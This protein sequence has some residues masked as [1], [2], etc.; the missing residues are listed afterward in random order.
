MDLQI[1]AATVVQGAGAVLLASIGWYVRRAV[2]RSD[3]QA[4]ADR[5]ARVEHDRERGIQLS[6]IERALG[7]VHDGQTA[8]RHDVEAVR[9][10]MRTTA[11][12]VGR[13]LDEHDRLAAAVATSAASQGERI[14]STER[15]VAVLEDRERRRSGA[16][17]SRSG[18]KQ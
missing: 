1:D 7:E 3:R 6:G 10:E 9:V 12:M 17:P 13:R 16:Q 8:L 4:E 5:Q 18:A 11:S 2:D 15:A 14:G